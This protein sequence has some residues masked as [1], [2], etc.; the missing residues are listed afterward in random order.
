MVKNN[1]KFGFIRPDSLIAEPDIF[2]MPV[3][4]PGFGGALPPVG[5]RLCYKIGTSPKGV[6]CAVDVE[7]AP[8][9][10]MFIKDIGKCGFIK[11]DTGE[12]DI[13]VMPLQC[14]GFGGAFPPIGTRVT[15][16]IGLSPQKGLPCAENVFPLEEAEMMEAPLALPW[17][18]N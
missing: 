10:G 2:V 8:R 14:T 9:T 4:C 5:A 13:F 3:Q 1:E 12:A 7:E 15:Y 6:P 17:M 18:A 11:Q 16:K